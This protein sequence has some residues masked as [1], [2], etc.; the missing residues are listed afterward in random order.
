MVP[1]TPR[2]RW[3][4]SSSATAAGTGRSPSGWWRSEA[5]R[6]RA[7]RLT[8]EL[9]RRGLGALVLPTLTRLATVTGEEQ[10][11]RRRVR[12]QVFSAEEH[13]V[14]DAFVDASLVVSDQDPTDSP[15]AA[16]VEVAHEALLR[17]WP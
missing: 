1:W 4:R 7:D 2:G 17:Q 8:D 12:S 15:A 13:V 6:S 5:L 3:P 10:P 14:I 16:V 9:G 11:T